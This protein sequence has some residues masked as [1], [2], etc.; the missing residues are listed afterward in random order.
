MC[1]E[2]V[3]CSG[4]FELCSTAEQDVHDEINQQHRCRDCEAFIGQERLT[5]LMPEI[6]LAMTLCADRP[7][8]TPDTPPTVSSGWMLTPT[9]CIA[10]STPASTASHDTR[11]LQPTRG[12]RMVQ[13]CPQGMCTC[14]VVCT[15]D[16]IAGSTAEFVS[17][18]S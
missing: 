4:V 2:S 15:S 13:A 3:F 14:D 12:V 1:D 9:T 6:V 18:D 8:M 11:P 16:A 17:S 5:R 7:T 10:I